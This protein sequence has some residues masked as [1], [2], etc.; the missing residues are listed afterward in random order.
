MH[1]GIRKNS[2]TKPLTPVEKFR[3]K[4]K[5]MQQIGKMIEGPTVENTKLTDAGTISPQ[6]S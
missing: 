6:G 3:N 2:I 4:Q 5:L 1:G